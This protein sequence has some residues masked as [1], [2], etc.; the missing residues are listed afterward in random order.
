M[1]VWP[2]RWPSERHGKGRVTPSDIS[3]DHIDHDDIVI[4]SVRVDSLTFDGCLDP[5]VF[6]DWVSNMDHYFEWYEMSE[7]HRV[8]FANMKLVGHAMLY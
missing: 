7:G 4:R 2:S 1:R 3:H 6:L 5:E 8:R